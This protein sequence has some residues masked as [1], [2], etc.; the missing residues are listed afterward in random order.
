MQRYIKMYMVDEPVGRLIILEADGTSLFGAHGL[1]ISFENVKC[2][3][4]AA[5][6]C[7]CPPYPENP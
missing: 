7:R 5:S 1:G 4:S 3:G 2:G 6:I